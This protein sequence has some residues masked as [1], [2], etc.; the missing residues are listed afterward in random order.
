MLSDWLNIESGDFIMHI[1]LSVM[2]EWK[3]VPIDILHMF[4]IECLIL[5]CDIH[6]QITNLPHIA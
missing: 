3:G 6:S 2:F 4:G 5:F 1:L